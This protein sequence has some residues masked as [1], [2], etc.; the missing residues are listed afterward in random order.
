VK[1]I[2][3]AALAGA[4]VTEAARR[5]AR[6]RSQ[7]RQH[8]YQGTWRRYGTMPQTWTETRQAMT[9]HAAATAKAR[10]LNAAERA[11]IPVP[12]KRARPLYGTQAVALLLRRRHD[13][14]DDT[15][16]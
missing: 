2:I 4:A 11:G 3:A 7:P 1:T 8:P 10:A 5:A 16:W 6:R 14:Y 9:R 12:R 13:P 15:G